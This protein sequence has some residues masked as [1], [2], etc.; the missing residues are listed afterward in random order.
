[1]QA[2][3]DGSAP[4]ALP[5]VP[6]AIAR[7][8]V[9][10]RA[11]RVPQSQLR[12]TAT[13]LVQRPRVHRPLGRRAAVARVPGLDGPRAARSNKKARPEP[14]FFV[15]PIANDQKLARTPTM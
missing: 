8:E 14:G 6:P 9:V 1:V 12:G 10:L 2:P 4:G 3:E 7:S 11:R 13:G 15:L 5:D